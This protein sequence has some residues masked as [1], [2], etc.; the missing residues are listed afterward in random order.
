MKKRP[1]GHDGPVPA[2]R[3]SSQPGQLQRLKSFEMSRR[4]NRVVPGG[5]HTAAR[6]IEPQIAWDRAEGAYIWDVDGNRYLDCHAAWG[7]VILGHCHPFVTKKVT[8]AIQHSDLFGTG[9]TNLEVQF[10][11]KICQHVPS[12]EMVLICN[13]GSSATYHAVRV[14]RAFTGRQR[15]IKFQGG[16]H[17]WHDYLLRNTI[18]KPDRIYKRDPGSAGMLEEAVDSTLVCRLNDLDDVESTCNKHKGEIAA[19]VVEPLAHNIGCVM[20]EDEFLQGLRQV[21]DEHGIVL[22]FDEVVTGFR[23]GLGGYQA[24]C[25]VKP[26]LTTLGKAIANGYPIAALAGRRDIMERFNTCPEGDVF[27]AGTYNAHPAATAAALATMEV[28][29]NPEVYKHIFDLGARM[30]TGLQE[31]IDRLSL[32]ATVVGYGSVFLIYWGTGP[33][34]NYEDLLHL[35]AE[36]FLTFRRGMIERGFFFVPMHLKRALFSHAHTE[37]DMYRT[38]EA[39]EDTLKEMTQKG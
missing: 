25:G 23:V 31:I 10:S 29:E 37:A 15:V 16:F 39:A 32:Q 2:D 28:L 11:E 18:S 19:I 1:Q 3:R 33:F 13:T 36:R 34:N 7:P 12:A 8:E 35:D 24:I 30:R 26:D 17:G 6:R 38:L 22:V 4:A 27:F 21:A 9:T 14:S 5:V 20:L